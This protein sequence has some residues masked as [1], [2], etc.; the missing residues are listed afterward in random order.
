MGVI[1]SD[2][3]VVCCLFAAKIRFFFT[4]E[5]TS[6]SGPN[7]SIYWLNNGIDKSTGWN[8]PN[9]TVSDL[10]YRDLKTVT[11]EPNNIYEPCA[12][13]VQMFEEYGEE[14]GVPPIM[15]AAFAMQ[16]SSCNP[17]AVG[18]GGEQGLMQISKDKCGGAPNGNCKDPVSIIDSTV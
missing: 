15:M 17:D 9:V 10:V 1:R 5:T 6:T 18:E 13:Y 3:L 7:G 8:P 12:P 4:G 11:A 16:E 2:K 14:F